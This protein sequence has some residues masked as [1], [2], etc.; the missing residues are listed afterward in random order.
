MAPRSIAVVAF[1]GISPFHLSI[2][3]I[4]FGVH[5][6][7]LGIPRYKFLVCAVERG[8]LRTSGGFTIEA[9]HGLAELSAADV[10]IVPSWRDP[11]EAAPR[12]L[13]DALLRA[14][15]R[16]AKI[17]GLCLGSFA[18]AETGILDG[19]RATTH[20][21]WAELFGRRFPN[22]LLEPEKL[23]VDDGEILT[24]A[25]N[26]AGLDCCLHLF[27][28]HHGAD[29]ANRL[30]RR[31]V[32]SPHRQGGQAQFI[33]RPMQVD[34]S[35]DRLA[36]V[37]AWARANPQLPHTIDSLAQR[38]LLGSRTFA[39]RFQQLTGTP[40]KRWL[41]EQRLTAAQRMLESSDATVEEIAASIGF[42]D[43]LSLR[44]HFVNKLQTTP[45]TYRKEFRSIAGQWTVPRK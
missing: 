15:E 7:E 5:R 2:P 23:Y 28:T 8:A 29:M 35:G 32:I 34:R 21:Y 18:I 45:S 37:V 40:V 20:W 22:V 41:I 3:G 42:A 39:R 4:V 13:V 43:S 31:L 1:D 25:G 27:R 11:S 12:P 17:V 44:Q 10:V 33:E 24:S 16:G 9:P 30:A 26:A 14:H 19:R 6:S 38:A 36:Q